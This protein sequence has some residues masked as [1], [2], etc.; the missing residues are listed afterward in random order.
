MCV[1]GVRND[2]RMLVCVRG[3]RKTAWGDRVQKAGGAISMTNTAG[4]SVSW[5]NPS[6]EEERK[7]RLGTHIG[8]S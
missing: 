6:Q 7:K 5:G 3:M 1:S 2:A 8:H 4:F